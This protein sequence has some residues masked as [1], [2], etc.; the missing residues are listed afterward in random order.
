MLALAA[1]IGKV[2]AQVVGIKTNLLYWASASPNLG[3]EKGL[4]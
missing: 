1:F 2:D 4:G 3:V